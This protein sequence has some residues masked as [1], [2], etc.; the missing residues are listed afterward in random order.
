MAVPSEQLFDTEAAHEA[1]S[2]RAAIDQD[3][4]TVKSV[5]G[6]RA[7]VRF[8]TRSPLSEDIP[9]GG[10]GRFVG[11]NPYGMSKLMKDF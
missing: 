5:K 10:H 7:V 6:P 2:L 8:G 11:V 1:S 4:I 3:C 9:V